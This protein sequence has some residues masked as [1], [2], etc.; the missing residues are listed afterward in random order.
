[1]IKLIKPYL[2]L[3]RT[4]NYIKN[5]FVFTPMF[6]LFDFTQTN[7]IN[8]LCSFIAFSLLASSV[9]IGN[10]IFDVKEDREHPV[11]KKR[12]IANGS[13]NVVSAIV[14]AC[15]LMVFAFAMS[16]QI[17]LKVFYIFAGYVLLNLCYNLGLKKIPIV[18]IIVIS[19]GFVMRVLVGAFATEIEPSYW[20]L[21]MTFLLAFFLALSKRRADKIVALEIQ[22]FTKNVS[23]YTINSITVALKIVA[24]LIC[25]SY[26]IYTVT[27]DLETRIGNSYA[28]VTCFWV[29]IG[30]YQYI[31]ILLS[32]E[33]Y[34]TPISII[35]KQ[36]SIQLIAVGWGIT[37]LILY[38]L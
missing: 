29:W 22:L 37:F 27:G 17:S 13:I 2:A 31:K 23:L 3:L 20:I 30:I 19:I 32:T 1:M 25:I 35:T 26:F 6:F 36:K 33:E 4:D 38:A 9:Y 21:W 11:K 14:I 7:F 15:V 10:D 18:D 34:H 5:I 8:T 24:V 12:P 28:F 16:Y